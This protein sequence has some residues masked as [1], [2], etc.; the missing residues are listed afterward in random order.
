MKKKMNIFIV[1][2]IFS[3][4]LLWFSLFRFDIA[5]KA[6]YSFGLLV[7][8]GLLSHIPYIIYGGWTIC[9]ICFTL[10]KGENMLLGRVLPLA[11]IVVTIL[12]LTV[13]PYTDAYVSLNY[14]FN[15]ENFSKTIEMIN[16]GEIQ[17]PRTNMNEF[18]VPYR[19]TSYTGKLYTYENDDVTKIMFF[20]YS[21]FRGGVVLVYSSDDSEI[22][23]IEFQR[24]FE[25]IKRVDDNWYSARINY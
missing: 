6:N 12:L 17:L 9:V 7:V 23:N 2:I 19:L 20:A 18:I 3:I 10:K 16:D 11:T 4:V 24:I 22:K 25:N 1:S 14:K 21:G 13:F 15:K 8:F 5:I